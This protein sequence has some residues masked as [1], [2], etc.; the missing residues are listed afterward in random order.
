MWEVRLGG[1]R[2][3]EASP[4]EGIILA[5]SCHS[6]L[7]VPHSVSSYLHQTHQPS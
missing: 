2:S 5:T 6:L 4:W 7:L 3:L 1:S